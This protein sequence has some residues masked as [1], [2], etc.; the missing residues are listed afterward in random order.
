MIKTWLIALSAIFLTIQEAQAAT[1][2]QKGTALTVRILDDVNSKDKTVP[3]AIVEYDLRGI[4]GKVLISKGTPVL[5]QVDRKKAK[6]CG[7]PGTLSVRC[8]S[9][10]ATDGQDILLDGSLKKEGDDRKAISYGIG[11]G[12]GLF[13][14]VGFAFLAI[15]GKNAAIESNTLIPSVLVMN[16][17]SIE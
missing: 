7:K 16:D 2:L 15:C 1:P 14:G 9:T 8:I 3:Q 11:I 10:V 12:S 17:Y 6:G 4:D 13:T 5:V